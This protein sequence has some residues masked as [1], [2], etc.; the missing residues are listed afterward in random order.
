[1][2]IQ[3]SLDEYRRKRDPKKTPEPRG[4]RKGG[5][6]GAPV[7]VVQRHDARRLH[8]DLRLEMGGALAS[9]A[10]PKGLPLEPGERYLAVHTEDHPMEYATFSGVIP[11]GQYGAGTME[12]WD[13]GTYELLERKRDGGLTVRLS[14]ERLQGVWTLVPAKLGGDE[15][16]WLVI[17]K[18]DGESAASGGTAA[19]AG[20]KPMLATLTERLPTGKGWTFEVKW[21][22][23]RAIARLEGGEASLTSRRGIDL[24]ARFDAVRTALPHGLRT[25]DCVVDGE[26]CMLDEQ[27]RPSFG[28]VQRSEGV[29]VFYLFDLLELERR[30]LTEL[31]LEERRRMLQELLVE[32]NGTVR[33]SAGFDDGAGLYEAVKAQGLEG[34]IAKR[35]GSTYRPG[36]RSHDW[37]K[38]KSRNDGEFLIAGWTPGL[39]SREQL[40]SLVLAEEGDEGL[41]WVGNVGSG[42]DERMIGRLLRELGRLKTTT[43]TI[44]PVPKMPK[45]P[46]RLVRWVEP[47]L[48]CKVHFAER[49]RDGRLRA[50]VFTGLIDDDTERPRTSRVAVSNHDKVFFP[51]EGITKGD[52]FAYYEAIAPTV[53]R[54]LRDRPFTMLRYPDGIKGKSFFQKDAPSHMPDWIETFNHEGIRYALVNNPDSLLWMIN[55]GCIDLHPWLARRDRPERPDLVMFDLDPAEGTPFSDV[56]QAA[57]LVREALDALGLEGVP[58][59][60]GGKGIHVL[61]PVERRYE[62]RE[63]RAFVAAV[64]KALAQTH[65]ELITTKWRKSERHGVLIDANQNGLGR[66]TAGAYSVR[67]RPGATV[68]TPLLWDELTPELDPSAFTMDAVVERVSRIGDV[69]EPLLGRRQRLP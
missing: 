15:K 7:F 27:G 47:R 25:S 26:L 57:Q 8:Y 68:A 61:V 58:R 17:R 14:G 60:S 39:G 55:M 30:P 34:V 35:L 69:A 54:H 56:V 2:V 24:G 53:A 36:K 16:N 49:T 50:P 62:H 65:P 59:T 52:L 45:T 18:H 31:P 3:M 1:M 6:G 29:P 41:R 67:P 12:I 22:G 46:A 37:L 9:W 38:I 32:G 28:L 11:K 51:D 5:T 48:R 23:Y 63:A 66:T 4:S 19:P 43:P 10:L 44:T 20:Y 40:G 13:Q 21:D 64:A 33:L 42:L